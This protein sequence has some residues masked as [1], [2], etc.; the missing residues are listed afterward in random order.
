MPHSIGLLSVQRYLC[1][2]VQ[3]KMEKAK[4]L[5]FTDGKVCEGAT[6]AVRLLQF[7]LDSSPRHRRDECGLVDHCRQVGRGMLDEAAELSLKLWTR[8]HI[9]VFYTF[10]HSH[11]T[12]LLFR[13]HYLLWEYIEVTANE[14]TN[15][16][17]QAFRASSLIRRG[18]R[19]NRALI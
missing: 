7:Y 8:L 18:S 11:S 5:R 6:S 14:N 17:Q 10:P 15:T 3:K 2:V 12:H 9:L 16:G 1:S 4:S 13:W 19:I